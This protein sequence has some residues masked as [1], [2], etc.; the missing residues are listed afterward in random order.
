MTE[1]FERY[2]HLLGTDG[3]P[4]GWSGLR[5]L[6]RRH[7]RSRQDAAHHGSCCYVTTSGPAVPAT[8][9]EYPDGI[10][11][12]DL[13]GTCYTINPSS[14]FLQC[15]RIS[16]AYDGYSLDLIDRKLYPHEAGKT[17]VTPIETM[18]GLKEAVRGSLGM[19]RCPVESAVAALER[20]T[21]NA[22]F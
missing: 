8:L 7:L 4:N 13:G 15:L 1:P 3:R 10:E 22:W 17:T 20:L 21:G 19:P 2:L 14:T 11:F 9:T 18:A 5:T 16:R 12:S 6:V